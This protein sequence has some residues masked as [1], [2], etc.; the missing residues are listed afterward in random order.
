MHEWGAVLVGYVDEVVA[1][2]ANRTDATDVG[3]GP[4]ID[5]HQPGNAAFG[6]RF[7][8]HIGGRQPQVRPGRGDVVDHHGERIWVE[9]WLAALGD[10][11]RRTG[12]DGRRGAWRRRSYPRAWR[13]DGGS[14]GRA[15]ARTGASRGLGW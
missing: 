14:R 13:G 10:D 7:V 3:A 9:L 6:G 11:R 8:D 15:G 5:R 1:R 4:Q 2:A 12:D